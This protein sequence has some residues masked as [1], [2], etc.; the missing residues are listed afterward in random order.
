MS[1]PELL[2]ILALRGSCWSLSPRLGVKASALA[3]RVDPHPSPEPVGAPSLFVFPFRTV[4]ATIYWA[5][6]NARPCVVALHQCKLT[7][8]E[9]LSVPT[10]IPGRGVNVA[11]RNTPDSPLGWGEGQAWVTR[12][13]GLSGR[14]GLAKPK[15]LVL[16]SGLVQCMAGRCPMASLLCLAG[17]A[18]RA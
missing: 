4:M 18:L 6:T 2:V 1:S 16:T 3:P 14:V 5:T 11:G 8:M 15:A 17:M 13:N 12:A 10:L 7:V 9:K